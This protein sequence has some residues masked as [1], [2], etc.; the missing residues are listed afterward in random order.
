MRRMPGTVSVERLMHE[1]E[2]EVR[3][4][5]R[6]RLMAPGGSPAYEDAEVFAIVER[7]LRR[8]LEDRDAEV[9]LLPDLLG[10]EADWRLDEKLKWSSHRPFIGPALILLKR[11]LL[12]PLMRWLER[13][14]SE[15]FRRQ[16]RIN[17]LLFA[18]V[19]ELAIENARLQRRAGSPEARVAD[20]DRPR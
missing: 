18:C 19:E 2:D 3:R 13:Y 12:L 15:N 6:A 4:A 16:Q 14:T 9:L 10:D 5:R 1:I 11:R 17:L 8:G 7:T 20:A